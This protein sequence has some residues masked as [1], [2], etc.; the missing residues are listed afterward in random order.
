MLRPLLGVMMIAVLEVTGCGTSRGDRSLTGMGVGAGTGALVG[1]L[2]GGVG[3]LPGALIGGGVGGA[4]GAV[5]N[6]DQ[7]DLG[8][9]IWSRHSK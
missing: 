8:D 5:T 1:A 7:L 2:F 3:L 9:P 6:R 4:T